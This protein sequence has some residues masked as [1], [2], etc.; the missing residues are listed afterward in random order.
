MLCAGAQAEAHLAV[1]DLLA[2]AQALEAGVAGTAAA[3]A[4]SDWV[5]AARARATANQAARLLHAHSTV[6]CASL[7]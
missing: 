4:V 1:G 6:L 7:S 5:H 3:A 2:A